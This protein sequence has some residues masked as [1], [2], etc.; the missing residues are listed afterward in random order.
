LGRIERDRLSKYHPV[1]S[2]DALS[3]KAKLTKTTWALFFYITLASRK[4]VGIGRKEI[5]ADRI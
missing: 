3:V 5:A 4:N 2:L 1:F